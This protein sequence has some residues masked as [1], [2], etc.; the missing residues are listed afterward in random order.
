VRPHPALGR[1]AG[2]VFLALAGVAALGLAACAEQR[3]APGASAYR[4]LPF[5]SQVT[6]TGTDIPG[7][8]QVLAA[9]LAF[10]DGST[11]LGVARGGHVEAVL[12]ARVRGHGAFAGHWERDDEVVDPVSVFITYGDTLVVRLGGPDLFPTAESGRHEVRFVIDAPQG[13]PPLAPVSYV[14]Q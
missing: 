6:V 1:P 2:F 5:R 11:T 4:P 14:V 12:S 3:V 9:S 8:L 10:P 7:P 13:A